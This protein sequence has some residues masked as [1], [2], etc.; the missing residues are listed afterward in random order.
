MRHRAFLTVE[1]IL[2]R[3]L[4]HARSVQ[5][6]KVDIILREQRRNMK[7]IFLV[8]LVILMLYMMLTPINGQVLP[9]AYPTQN[10]AIDTGNFSINLTGNWHQYYPGMAVIYINSGI[11]CESVEIELNDKYVGFH[12][13]DF[14]GRTE[15]NANFEALNDSVSAWARENALD[16]INIEEKVVDGQ[17]SAVLFATD[18]IGM[19]VRHAE[20]WPDNRTQVTIDP[21]NYEPW[22]GEGRSIM[23]DILSGVHVERTNKSKHEATKLKSKSSN[24]RNNSISNDKYQSMQG[25]EKEK[26]IAADIMKAMLV[27][28]PRVILTNINVLESLPRIEIDVMLN[29]S[30]KNDYENLVNFTL[31]Y[32][33]EI[34]RNSE[35]NDINEMRVNWISK[36]EYE[37][38]PNHNGLVTTFS[39]M[40]YV[41]RENTENYINGKISFDELYLSA[42]KNLFGWE[43]Y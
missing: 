41:D 21:T 10:I 30:N 5:N 1:L 39:G 35:M 36:I 12:I 31:D 33:A 28:N 38:T 8:C 27:D 13:M 26:A 22:T 6:G 34:V 15:N 3:D 20:Y 24:I 2:S 19:E 9:N 32:F 40:M 37:N 14:A 18:Y 11:P 43:V 25:I 17:P 42:N 4:A 23:D 7:R 29:E 16:V